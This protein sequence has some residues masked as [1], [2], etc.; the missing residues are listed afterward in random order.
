MPLST[1]RLRDIVPVLK[2]GGA[3]GILGKLGQPGLPGAIP[4]L[5][6]MAEPLAPKLLTPSDPVMG[7]LAGKGRQGGISPILRGGGTSD[8]QRRGGRGIL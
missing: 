2:G 5:K 3:G 8:L 6:P 4:V 1:G 7:A